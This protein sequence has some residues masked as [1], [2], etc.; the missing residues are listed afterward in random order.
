MNIHDE[1]REFCKGRNLVL[2]DDQKMTAAFFLQMNNY[3]PC[4]LRARR[5]GVTT[6][7]NALEEFYKFHQPKPLSCE[8]IE[9][10]EEDGECLP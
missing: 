5:S 7:F 8:K 10:F 9:L 2:N 1:F 4:W 3:N 6:L